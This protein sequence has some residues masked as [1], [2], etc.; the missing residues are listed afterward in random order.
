MPTCALRKRDQCIGVCIGYESGLHR[1]Y[2]RSAIL[3]VIAIRLIVVI[4]IIL[5]V[6][7]AILLIVVIVIILIVAIIAILVR[8]VVRDVVRDAPRSLRNPPYPAPT[9]LATKE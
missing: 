3:V 9:S 7:I 2:I 6:V 1:A 4:A 8:F 5:I